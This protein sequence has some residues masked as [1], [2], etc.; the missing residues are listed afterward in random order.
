MAM[1]RVHSKWVN[2]ALQFYDVVTGDILLQIDPT[3]LCVSSI[4][5]AVYDVPALTAGSQT[6]T[7]AQA[8]ADIL[9]VA[10]GSNANQ[11]IA[12]LIDG[13]QFIV[14]NNDA[15][16]N[17]V[18]GGATGNTVTIAPSTTTFV[19]TDGTNYYAIAWTASGNVTLTGAQ[20][21]TQKTLTA[22]V[23]NS[24]VVN[25]LYFGAPHL[26]T[27]A[28]QNYT[29]QATDTEIICAAVTVAC[30]VNLP[31]GAQ[32]AGKEFTIFKDASAITVAVTPASGA[33][34]GWTGPLAASAIHSVTLVSDGTNY[35]C[36]AA[37]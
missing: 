26:V 23:L 5:G 4:A 19:W 3:N 11:I 28:S 20:T 18:I 36:K 29:A 16:N 6:L 14:V 24:P 27:G 9:V 32:W 10:A 37:V 7:A 21:L 35:W 12:P 22:P 1:A 25:G 33:I 15:I 8:L 30:T 17:V 13:T 2:G 31:Q 34:E